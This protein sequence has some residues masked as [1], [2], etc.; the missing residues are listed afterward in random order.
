MPFLL[1]LALGLVVQTANTPLTTLSGHIDH[2]LPADSVRIMLGFKDTLVSVNSKGDFYC[3]LAGMKQAT[4]TKLNYGDHQTQ[5]YLTPG[6]RIAMRVDYKNFN[7]SIIYRGRGSKINNYLAQ[8]SYKFEY[9]QPTGSLRVSAFPTGTPAEA[10]QAATTLR[11]ARR[12]FLAA[13]DKAHPLPTAF[14]REQ[15]LSFDCDWATQQLGY[16][17][18]H[19][20]DTMPAG[21]FDF[22][23]QVPVR[24]VERLSK[25]SF[26]DN[27][28]L[29]NLVIGYPVRLV[30]QG[31]LSLDP[32]QGERI[33]NTATEELGDGQ[34]CAW[35]IAMLFQQNLSRNVAGA[36]VF[37]QSLKRLTKDSTLVESLREDLV[38][39]EKLK[40][41]PAPAFTLL[42]KDKKPVSLSDFRGK[43]VYL[44]FWGT[45]CPPCMHELNK[46]APGLRQKLARQDVVFICVS[47]GDSE[48]RWLKTIAD[49]RFTS[50]N[51][52]HLRAPDRQVANLYKVS[53]FP[54]YFIIGRDGKMVQADAPR[55]SDTDT[56][57]KALEEALKH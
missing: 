24:E 41:N 12:D 42:D 25:R 51:S 40:G 13:Y 44:D 20:T 45:W 35:A 9:G 57:S 37:Y 56:V 21:Y 32:Q 19:R 8:D 53:S 30:P 6:D 7:Q 26:I 28:R 2:P 54:S 29:A 23:S 38:A 46:F 49:E 18:K 55:P 48:G 39:L 43:V 47:V 17:Y 22:M 14:V 3:K 15:Q 16:A 52:V 1:S 5:L 11:Q 33:Y 27:S 4:P 34:A 10:R 36:G 50:F 31:K